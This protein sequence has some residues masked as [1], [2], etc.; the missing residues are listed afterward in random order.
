V[1]LSRLYSLFHGNVNKPPIDEAYT[2][3]FVEQPNF[4]SL[5]IYEDKW[6][7]QVDAKI[8]IHS[9]I[10]PRVRQNFCFP[11]ALNVKVFWK[12]QPPCWRFHSLQS[13][14]FKCV[15]W[16]LV[17]IAAKCKLSSRIL[18]LCWT[19]RRVVSSYIGS[20]TLTVVE[21]IWERRI[22]LCESLQ[23]TLGF[24]KFM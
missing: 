12:S 4:H 6:Y 16:G 8:N 22:L 17:A 15:R 3:T 21:C 20:I 5:N 10:L 13:Q 9:M 7:N 1:A 14:P 18:Q 23:L 11:F 19:I 24:I 2:V